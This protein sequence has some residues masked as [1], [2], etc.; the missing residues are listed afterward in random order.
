MT[1]LVQMVQWRRQPLDHNA[2]VQIQD[3][4]W[5]N[6][7]VTVSSAKDPECKAFSFD[8]PSIQEID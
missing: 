5:P 1:S 6:R 2:T 4:F 8:E 7:L 3:L